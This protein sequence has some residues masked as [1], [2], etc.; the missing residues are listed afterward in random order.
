LRTPAFCR[1]AVPAMAERQFAIP[2]LLQCLL[3]VVFAA[4]FMGLLGHLS[5]VQSP[6]A[7][8]KGCCTGTAECR[9]YTM[10]GVWQDLRS[11]LSFLLGVVMCGLFERLS[12]PAA[13]SRP[14]HRESVPTQSSG[15][16]AL[17]AVLMW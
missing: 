2:L 10:C 4:S 7:R 9:G 1:Q 17:D 6:D 13:S 14:E 5:L 15:K 16:G 3:A 8:C 12:S 11:V